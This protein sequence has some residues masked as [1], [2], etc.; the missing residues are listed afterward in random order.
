MIKKCLLFLTLLPVLIFGQSEWNGYLQLRYF[1]DYQDVN[2]FTLRRAKIWLKGSTAMPGWSY[3]LQGIFRWQNNGALLLQ[4]AFLQYTASY[5]QLR[6]GQMVPDFSLQRNQP[7]YAIPVIER[8]RVVDALIPAA[9]TMA[10][11]I[12]LMA[13][14]EPQAWAFHLSF[15]IFNGNGANHSFNEDRHFLYTIRATKTIRLTNQWQFS[16]GFSFSYR[17]CS[18]LTF[19]KIFNKPVTFSG[20]DRRLAF[21]FLFLNDRWLIQGEFL[22]ARL[23]V[24]KAHGFYLLLNKTIGEKHSFAFSLE[25]FNDLA[26]NTPNRLYYIVEYGYLLKTNKN[27]LLLDLR[28]QPDGHRL[29]FSNA[30]QLQLFFN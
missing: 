20:N 3:K 26:A 6:F 2:S 11:D 1:T 28:A 27:K 4:D 18:G 9:E 8:A 15:G 25:R 13:S 16:P 29:N 19:K 12:G 17:K 5:L 22:E 14:I 7:D 10:R 30:I 21:E 24:Q 23:N